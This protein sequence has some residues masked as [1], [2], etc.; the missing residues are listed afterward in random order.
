MSN[1]LQLSNINRASHAVGG[2]KHD[3]TTALQSIGVAL[4]PSAAPLRFS[5]SFQVVAEACRS[6]SLSVQEKKILR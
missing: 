6:Y 2:G 3:R 1:L 5:F 4:T